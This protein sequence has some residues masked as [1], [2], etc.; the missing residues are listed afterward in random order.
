MRLFADDTALYLTMESE[1]DS[2]ALQ[3]D[4]DILSAL[5]TRWDMEFKPSK[6]QVVHVTG[7]RKM[8]KTNYVLHG[9]VLESVPC[10]RYLG[11]DISSGLTWNSHIDGVTANANQTLGFIRRNIKTKMP[12]V[13][14]AAYNSLVRPQLE[15]ASAVW[16]PHTKV[17][18][19]QIEQVQRRA[20]AP[21]T[22]IT[23]DRQSSVTEMVK[24][25]G[26]QS[27]E[28]R[29]ADTRL[30]LFYKVIHGLVAVP[31]PDYIHYS[32]RI[33]RYCHSMTFRQV[34]TSTDYYKFSFFSLAI[35][36]WNS[37]LSLLHAC[38][39][40][41]HSRQPSAS[42]STHTHRSPKCLFL[43]DFS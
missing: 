14:E 25:L 13:R 12:K 21:W 11:V 16:D 40:L 7:S 42:C 30:C 37:S 15:Y 1:D 28:Q 38:K 31:L 17:R 19:S 41:M 5:E 8:V 32:N 3:T 22:A 36:Q 4:L 26:W 33:S 9:Q 18:I 2:S 23:F 10:A 29:R 34:S 20:A 6:C 39:A 43:T 24:Q 27:L 35:V